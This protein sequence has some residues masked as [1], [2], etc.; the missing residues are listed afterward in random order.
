MERIQHRR[1]AT[2]EP[3]FHIQ[4]LLDRR[5]VDAFRRAIQA[6]VT[7]GD[8]VV[9]TG[10]GSGLLALFAAESG[11]SRVFAVEIDPEM[12]SHARRNIAASAYADV[13]EVIET[14]VLSF[15][16][17]RKV[18]VILGEM[19]HGWLVEEVQ[20]PAF[21]HLRGWLRSGGRLVP[22]LVENNVALAETPLFQPGF[23]LH[24]PFHRWESE[25]AHRLL[26]KAV[27][28]ETIDLSSAMAGRRTGHVILEP[29]TSGTVDTVVLR[30]R[31]LLTDGIWIGETPTM[32][33]AIHVPVMPF[34]VCAGDAVPVEY[35]YILGGRWDQL[36]MS[37][38]R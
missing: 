30:S 3:G 13:V 32:L 20:V 21:Q 15:A 18:D 23:A 14:D 31:A 9:D 4:M 36:E 5:R 17:G 11:A 29:S 24:A 34:E 2:Y 25:E 35:S 10:T 19:L 33:P 38:E 27:I 7:P 37:V 12:A 16:P 1:Q 26:C 8:V 22:R 28:T 6:V